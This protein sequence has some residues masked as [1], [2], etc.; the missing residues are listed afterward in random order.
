MAE[1][2]IAPSEQDF[3]FIRHSFRPK[4]V[5]NPEG[6]RAFTLAVLREALGLLDQ[7]VQGVA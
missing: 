3:A 1:S 5:L 4:P 2:S 7:V 6:I